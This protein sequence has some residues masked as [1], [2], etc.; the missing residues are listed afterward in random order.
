M[1]V[2]ATSVRSFEMLEARLDELMEAASRVDPQLVLTELVEMAEVALEHW[3]V[4]RGD[5]PTDEQ[6]EG[7]RLLALQRQGSKGDP[8]F[9]ACR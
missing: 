8:S 7:F 5:V 1:I 2:Q 9:N 6:R 4:A 3:V